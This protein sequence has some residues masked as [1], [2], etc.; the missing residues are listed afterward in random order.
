M[1]P[2]AERCILYPDSTG[3]MHRFPLHSSD[4][5]GLLHAK[6]ALLAWRERRVV[7]YRSAPPSVLLVDVDGLRYYNDA[8]GMHEGTALMAK[9]FGLLMELAPERV[10]RI[11]ADGFLVLTESDDEVRRLP[12]R[13]RRRFEELAFEIDHPDLD[14]QVMTVRVGICSNPTVERLG[15]ALWSR[16]R[17]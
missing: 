4:E 11:Y 15:K 13:I 5:F 6:E 17:P 12:P 1:R 3:T 16:A 8:Y 10:F 9:L 2:T 14:K 7:H